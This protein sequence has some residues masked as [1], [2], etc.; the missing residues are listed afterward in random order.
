MRLPQIEERLL[1]VVLEE[2]RAPDQQVVE[3]PAV[4]VEPQRRAQQRNALRG[5]PEVGVDSSHQGVGVRVGGIE[6]HRL[7]QGLER[8]VVA[9]A[10]RVHEAE[11]PVHLGD[12]GVDLPRGF[13]ELERALERRGGFR[14]R[15]VAIV[16]CI[17]HRERRV[18]TREPGIKLQRLAE[19]RPRLLV[20]LRAPHQEERLPA[21][22]V[23][24][25][26]RIVRVALGEALP[27]GLGDAAGQALRHAAGN[28]ALQREEVAEGPVVAFG[29]DL[30]AG[31]RVHQAH[32]YADPRAVALHAPGDHVGRD[33]GVAHRWADELQPG[34]ARQVRHEVAADAAR[35][36]VV[37]LAGSE[38]LEGHHRHGQRLGDAGGR[39]RAFRR[40]DVVGE[41]RRDRED[42]GRGGDPPAPLRARPRRRFRADGSDE[43][44]AALGDRLDVGGRLRAVA[45]RPA[46]LDDALRQRLVAHDD[47]TPDLGEQPFAAHDFAGAD[48]KGHEHFH[49]LRLD[50]YRLAACLPQLVGRRI[51]PPLADPQPGSHIHSKTLG[52]SSGLA[53]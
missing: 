38:R 35:K 4:G 41:G 42:R 20:V 22:E 47:A 32:V 45:E 8:L 14:R 33:H 44:V 6:L 31:A 17:G 46:Q 39:P 21:Q 28:F 50:P 16:H 5:L 2:V 29:P 43:P 36:V 11:R 19:Q 10:L 13:G 3:V 30:L 49:G 7:A 23:V 34:K 52:V 26:L 48:R 1:D 9:A 18:R 15:L 12:A 51:G 24:V 25:G 37:L 27:L 53:P 40:G